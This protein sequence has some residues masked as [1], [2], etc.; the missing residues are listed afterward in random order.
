MVVRIAYFLSASFQWHS[1]PDLLLDR[2]FRFKIEVIGTIGEVPYA[3]LLSYLPF[4][5]GIKLILMFDGIINA[6]EFRA[7]NK[8]RPARDYPHCLLFV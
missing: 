2:L 3:P 7:L 5:Y 6:A 8:L 1:M 4:H